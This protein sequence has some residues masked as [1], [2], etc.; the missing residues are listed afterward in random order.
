MNFR[1]LKVLLTL[2]GTL[3]LILFS[4]KSASSQTNPEPG[5]SKDELVRIYTKLAQ[6]ETLKSKIVVLQAKH[7]TQADTIRAQADSLQVKNG[8][9]ANLR[10][11]LS[12]TTG[13]YNESEKERT[14]LSGEISS[15]KTGA[16]IFLGLFGALIVYL[17]FFRRK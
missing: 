10:S 9:I 2:C 8:A 4:S 16:F 1:K 5:L 17:L 7:Q 14:R 11:E 6:F 15:I 3:T 12:K 13:M